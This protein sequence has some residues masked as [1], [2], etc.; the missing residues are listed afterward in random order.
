MLC[1]VTNWSYVWLSASSIVSNIV[2][3]LYLW[4]FGPEG[5]VLFN[6]FKRI[7]VWA[8]VYQKFILVRGC[9][10]LYELLFEKIAS[11]TERWL[12]VFF[13]KTIYF[14][15]IFCFK[16]YFLIKHSFKYSKILCLFNLIKNKQ[17]MCILWY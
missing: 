5:V 6:I 8:K 4:L 15:Q 2:F 3:T 10:F 13:K 16:Y 7:I 17:K 9:C 11:F 1:I 12:F 14:I